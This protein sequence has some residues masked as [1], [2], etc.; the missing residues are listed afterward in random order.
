VLLAGKGHA[1]GESPSLEYRVCGFF[2]GGVFL[3]QYTTEALRNICLVGHGGAGKTSFLEAALYS[4]GAIDRMGRVDEGNTISDHD[5]EE[6]K[7]TISIA[8][9]LGPCE[10]QGNKINFVDT[11][12]YFDFVGEVKGA[13]RAADLA[14]IFAC[15]VSGVEVGTEKVFG[16]AGENNLPKAFFINKMDRENANFERV[17]E[18]LKETFGTSVAPF[19]IP[20]GAEASFVGVV[21]LLTQ[22]AY[23]YSDSGRKM[24]EKDVPADLADKVEEYRTSLIEAVAE[25]DDELLMKYLEGE[26][27]TDE[28]II[29]GA[30]IGTIT[31]K[32]NPV[33]CGSSLKNIGMK[34]LLESA[35]RYFPSPAD[36]PKQV[37]VNPKTGE[38]VERSATTSAPFSAVVFKTMADPYVGKLSLFRVYSG[39]FKSDGQVYNS[40]K[41]SQERIGQLFVVRGKTQEAV[42]ELVAG[43]IGAVAKLQATGTGDTLC[44][45]DSAI[46]YAGIVFPDPVM[47]LAVEPKSKGDEEKIGSSFTRLQEED[48]T[49]VVKRDTATRQ[50]VISGMGDMHLEVIVSRIAKKFGVEVNL[51]TPRVAYRETIRGSTR[52][53]GKH[54]KQSGGKGQFGHVWIEMEPME[55]GGGF[56]FVDKIFGGSVPRQ[57]IPAVEKGIRETLDDG[58]LAGCQVVDI[59]VTLVDGSYHT[60]DSSEMAFKIAASLA[61]K[62][63]FMACKPILM[64]PIMNVEV[65]VPDEYMGDIIGDL[66]KK[67]GRIMGM[68]PHGSFQMVRAQ[69]PLAEMFKYATDLR[70]MTQGRA[71]FSM[72]PAHYEE[73]PAN[74]AEPI[75]AAAA[76]KDEE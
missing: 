24:E 76:K 68:E 2:K 64:E 30:R 49:F 14:F 32:L 31:G 13:L 71:S 56:E 74:V 9:S 72:T 11:P 45:K 29:R 7:R 3:K 63:G 18:Q 48:P 65:V 44:E 16:Y 69:A 73:V 10:W 28:E 4:S 21:D 66:N 67:R 38:E 23:Y 15:A 47:S 50:T 54:K 43:D 59:R 27:L 37:G 61:F 6:I 46:K 33:F 35:V 60:V 1:C 40:T 42:T 8:T 34:S 41:E 19:Q 26:A 57:Y 70:S 17:L 52:I 25:T 51:S 20:I 39:T 53:E 36:R 5:P 55:L 58:V 75:I 22:K 12:G 62:K